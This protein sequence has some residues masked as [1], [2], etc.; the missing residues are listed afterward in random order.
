MQ[1]FCWAWLVPER[2]LEKVASSSRSWVKSGEKEF[3][4]HLCLFFFFFNWL[5]LKSQSFLT[6]YKVFTSLTIFCNYLTHFLV[7]CLPP[8]YMK[9]TVSLLF[10]MVSWGTYS[11]ARHPVKGQKLF[12]KWVKIPSITKS[13]VIQIT[14]WNY[15]VSLFVFIW[16]LLLAA[17]HDFYKITGKDIA[18]G[19][20]E[21]RANQL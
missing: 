3:G 20:P 21:S 10:T 7:Y 15:M 13:R 8:W 17:H 5:D 11:S 18:W 9:K 4:T 1:Y 12:V 6:R 16:Y 14:L 2:Q 19:L